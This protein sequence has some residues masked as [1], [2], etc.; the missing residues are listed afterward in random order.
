MLTPK[1]K[2]LATLKLQAKAKLVEVDP[3]D[4]S[5][6]ACTLSEQARFTGTLEMTT[7]DK[8]VHK[9]GKEIDVLVQMPNYWVVYS[10]DEDGEG[11]ILAAYDQA[12]AVAYEMGDDLPEGGLPALFDRPIYDLYLPGALGV[13]YRSW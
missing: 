4:Y 10:I 12:K 13:W 8:V 5:G 6:A 11:S 3:V 7:L 2:A 9:Y 1:Q